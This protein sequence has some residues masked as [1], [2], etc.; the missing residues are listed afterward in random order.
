MID[1]PAM[2]APVLQIVWIDIVLSGDNAVVI[3]L[4]CRALPKRQ[5]YFGIVLGTGAAVGLRIVLTMVVVEILLLPYVR[6][7]GGLLLF[8]I[9]TKLALQ[10]H[11]KKHSRSR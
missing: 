4:A 11:G 6:L 8:W 10:D 2:L 3:G 7:I 1:I 9:A 5:R